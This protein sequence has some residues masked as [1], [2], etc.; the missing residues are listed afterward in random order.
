[1]YINKL[2]SFPQ[3]YTIDM[4]IIEKKMDIFLRKIQPE[5]RQ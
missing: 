5:N 2:I 3:A 1:M 4:Q